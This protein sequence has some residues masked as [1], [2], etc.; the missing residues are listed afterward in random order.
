MTDATQLT[1]AILLITVPTIALGGNFMLRVLS[2]GVPTTA[3]QRS[4]FR[5]GHAHAGVLVTLSLVALLYIDG[6]GIT[7][8]PAGVATTAIVVSPILI[9]AGFFLSMIGSGRTEPNGLKVLIHLGAISLGA[10]TLT[11]GGALLGA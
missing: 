1:A 2:G 6:A 4:F 5:A 3:Q 11:Q 10:G 7:G 8:I 9:P